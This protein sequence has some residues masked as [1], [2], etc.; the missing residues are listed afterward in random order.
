MS[1]SPLSPNQTV[2]S[3]SFDDS[4]VN[5]CETQSPPRASSPIGDDMSDK[6][7]SVAQN[8]SAFGV[9][10]NAAPLSPSSNSSS[11]LSPS[12]G[13]ENFTSPHSAANQSSGSD[14]VDPSPIVS[15][16]HT[17]SQPT[18]PIQTTPPTASSNNY[19]ETKEKLKQEKKERHA[20]KKLMK[21]FLPCKT[22]LEEMEVND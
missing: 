10:S 12:A 21:E 6:A 13:T 3:T 1:K 18:S 15:P 2:A 4:Q 16:S 20:T 19:A 5:N 11:V 9:A 14:S 17:T 22:M 8:H 7:S